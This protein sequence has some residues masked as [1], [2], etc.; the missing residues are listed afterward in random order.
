M[1][2]QGSGEKRVYGPTAIGLCFAMSSVGVWFAGTSAAWCWPP[3]DAWVA[4]TLG[5]VVW[6]LFFVLTTRSS[7]FL[8]RVGEDAVVAW[9]LAG[10]RTIPYTTIKGAVF[11][12]DPITYRAEMRALL[13]SRGR[14]GL[15]SWMRGSTTFSLSGAWWTV[16]ALAISEPTIRNG[17]EAIRDIARCAGLELPREHVEPER[18][19]RWFYVLWCAWMMLILVLVGSMIIPEM[20]TPNAPVTSG[21]H[22][23]LAP[24]IGGVLAF[25]AGIPGAV[26]FTIHL[27]RTPAGQ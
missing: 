17:E 8:L 7:P 16:P 25:G 19:R 15:A 22:L 13:R 27:F 24:L 23:P 14:S 10:P 4:W 3:H 12:T 26:L 1:T 6:T 5:P 2:E 9:T 18:K 20:L 21:A 11:R